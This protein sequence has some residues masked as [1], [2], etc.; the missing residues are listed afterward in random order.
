M[1]SKELVLKAELRKEIGSKRAKKLRKQSKIPAV[2]YG[3]KQEPESIVL[4]SHEFTE[5]LHHGQRL[6]D[7]QIGSKKE[8]M[9]LK[10]V[11]YDHL[12][13]TIIHADFVRV[14]LSERVKVEVPVSYKG[15]PVGAHEGGVLEEHLDRLEVECAVTEIPESIDVSVKALKVGES[16]HASDVVLPAG[17]KLITPL[18]AL[19]IA[20]HE[21]I[22]APV[23]EAVPAISEEAIV[24][25]VIT[26]RKPKEDE[27]SEEK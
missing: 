19:L 22:A 12:G 21:P 23:E 14:D 11:Q 4:G 3:H 8:K 16:I 13:K 2:V 10:E 15:V 20:C 9:L 27:E 7:I 1:A 17:V 26:E 24:P 5:S 25:E 6:Y 18:E